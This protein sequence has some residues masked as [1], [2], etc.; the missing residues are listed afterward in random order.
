MIE[1]EKA[2]IIVEYPLSFIIAYTTGTVKP[3]R[4]AGSARIPTKGT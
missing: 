1:A 2:A 4:M 3:P